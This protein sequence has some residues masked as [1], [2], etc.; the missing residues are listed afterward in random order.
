M[1]VGEP[2][3]G[4]GMNSNNKP[5]F[6]CTKYLLSFLFFA[7]FSIKC[8]LYLNLNHQD[9]E[10]NKNKARADEAMDVSQ[11]KEK[12]RK[13]QV[14]Q[15]VSLTGVCRPFCFALLTSRPAFPKVNI[16]AA[17]LLA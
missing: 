8:F 11:K 10:A 17:K 2:K 15:H 16:A 3:T 5:F 13:D 14:P 9:F 1:K 7:A 4:G 12:K 6:Y